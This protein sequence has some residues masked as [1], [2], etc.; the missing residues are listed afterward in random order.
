MDGVLQPGV[1]GTQL[2]PVF[3][4]VAAVSRASSNARN[5]VAVP[6]IVRISVV[7]WAVSSLPV[8]HHGPPVPEH[9]QQMLAV[10]VLAAGRGTL[11]R[12]DH[13]KVRFTSALGRCHVGGLGVAVSRTMKPQRCLLVVSHQAKRVQQHLQQVHQRLAFVLQQP[14]RGTGHCLQQL[15]QPL[16]GFTGTLLVL[17]GDVPLLRSTTLTACLEEPHGYGQVFCDDRQQVTAI[18]QEQHCTAQQRRNRCINGGVYCFHWPSL[19][20]RFTVED[21]IEISSINDQQPVGDL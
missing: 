13:P 1:D 19:A 15:L 17:N 21:E 20:T 6:T 12:S 8:D 14:Q 3:S 5:V 9:R 10:A 11:M 7:V 2:F 16:A 18:L 4:V